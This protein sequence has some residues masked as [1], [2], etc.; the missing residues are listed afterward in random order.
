[1]K[2]GFSAHPH[3]FPAAS[4]AALVS[5]RYRQNSPRPCPLNHV[6]RKTQ[7][8]ANYHHAATKHPDPYNSSSAKQANRTFLNSPARSAII[9]SASAQANSASISQAEKINPS[10]E[11]TTFHGINSDVC[12]KSPAAPQ[13]NSRT[14]N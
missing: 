7:F 8:P 13:K 6:T 10:N 12:G 14:M 5:R 3:D 1:M 11:P 9:Y 4:Y 2:I